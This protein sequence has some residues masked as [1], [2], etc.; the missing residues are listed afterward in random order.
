MSER[1]QDRHSTTE[2]E[3]ANAIIVLEHISKDS[4]YKFVHNLTISEIEASITE[5][6]NADAN[7]VRTLLNTPPISDMLNGFYGISIYGENA[8]R[9]TEQPSI[10]NERQMPNHTPVVQEKRRSKKLKFLKDEFFQ[11]LILYA[12]YLAWFGGIGNLILSSDDPIIFK[13][14]FL[15]GLLILALKFFNY[16]HKRG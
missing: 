16:L 13:I 12:L 10:V 15:V 4:Y 3:R 2:H 9:R 6:R 7:E 5:L 1:Y 11:S 8:V 14:F